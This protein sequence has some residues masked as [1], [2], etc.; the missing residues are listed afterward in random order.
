MLP[1]RKSWSPFAPRYRNSA[2]SNVRR[3]GIASRQHENFS[4][5]HRAQTPR[6]FTVGN[7]FTPC[8]EQ[9][10]LLDSWSQ[11]T[12]KSGTMGARAS[13]ALLY[14]GAILWQC[15]AAESTTELQVCANRT[16]SAPWSNEG[17]NGGNLQ[18][19]GSVLKGNL[20]KG[21][22]NR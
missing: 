9:R 8:S 13:A 1:N 14:S 4:T 5:I 15:C 22:Y 17:H 18:V 2:A 21:I 16:H 7:P 3:V 11:S 6:T 19:L 10:R 20:G 12:A